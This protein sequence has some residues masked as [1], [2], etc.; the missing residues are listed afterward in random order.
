MFYVYAILASAVE[1]AHVK[2]GRETSLTTIKL[3]Y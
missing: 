3:I 1:I 2:N